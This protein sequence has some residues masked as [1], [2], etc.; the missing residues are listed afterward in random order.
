MHLQIKISASK[1]RAWCKTSILAHPDINLRQA[2]QVLQEYIVKPVQQVLLYHHSVKR[3]K[4]FEMQTVYL[5]VKPSV[6]QSFNNPPFVP[7]FLHHKLC[8]FCLC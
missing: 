3:H 2:L 6:E 8:I 1:A 5:F 4:I 7:F